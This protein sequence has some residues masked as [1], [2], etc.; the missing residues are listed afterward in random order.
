MPQ[1]VKTTSFSSVERCGDRRLRGGRSGERERAWMT[2]LVQK[3][4]G[5]EGEMEEWELVEEFFSRIHESYGDE[6]KGK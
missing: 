2:R 3:E 4:G 1:V 5:K 6:D